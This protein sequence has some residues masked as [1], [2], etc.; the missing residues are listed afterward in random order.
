MK[1]ILSILV[2]L[3][4]LLAV[5]VYM[6]HADADTVY[7]ERCNQDVSSDDWQTW[8][9]TGGDV[10]G[11]HYRLTDDFFGQT[12]TIRIPEN[13]IVCLDLCGKTYAATK[14]R[15]LN[16]MGTFTLM[17]SV[18][19]GTIL[20]SGENG[21]Y[22]GFALVQSSGTFKMYGGTIRYS[23]VP[24][25]SPY[26]GALFYVDGGLLDIK[27]GTIAGGTVAATSSYI[28][29]GGN[30]TVTNSGRL[31]VYGGKITGGTGLKSSSKASQGG[32][33]YANKGSKVIV[34]GGVIENGYVDGGGGNIFIA[35]ASLEV[36]DGTIR[37]GHALVSGGNIMANADTNV[38]NT[39]TISGGE[40]VGGV[41]GGTY[42]TYTD[43]A[44]TRGTKGG[45]NI[46]ERSPSG[47][48]TISG[49][50]IDGDIVLDYVK[51][52]TLSGA[53][54][55]GLGKSGGLT[56]TNLSSFKADVKGLTAGAEIYVQ[57]T[58]VFTTAFD[59][60]LEAEAALVHFK[61]AV[62]T[63]I[64]TTSA[65]ALQGTQGETG[66]C[67]HCGES[68]TWTNLN[69]TATLSGHSYLSAGMLRTSNL[70]VSNTWV[71]DLNGY[72][73]HIE[74]RRFIFN[75]NSAEASL[76]IMD[77]WAGGK[78]Q[79]TGT[80]HSD[81][82]LM[83][84]WPNSTFEL[85]S[86]T[87]CLTSPL[88]DTTSQS[89]IVKCG[90]V[91]FAADKATIKISGGVISN[92]K[93]SATDGYGGN[94]AMI[95]KSGNLE[96][97]AGIINGGTATEL[98]GGNI[99]SNSP[100]NIS[101]GVILN[102]S[103]KNGGN[104]YSN[105]QCNITGGQILNGDATNY[106]GNLYVAAGADISAGLIA[107]GTADTA[108]GNIGL[109][110]GEADISGNTYITG[111]DATGRGGNIAVGSSAILHVSGGTITSGNSS[112]R[113][114]NIDTAT[115]TAIVNIDGG[116][117]L[118]GTATN[119]GNL[120]INNGQ[121]NITG[122]SVMAGAA[123]NGGN[124]YMN[125]F[126]YA[127]I[128]D[129][130]NAST[131][132]AS[133]TYGKATKGN[134][135]NIYLNAADA[136]TNYYLQLG[137][138]TVR[139]GTASGNGKNIY[140]HDNGVFT[141]LSEF[142]GNTTVYFAESRN[143]VKGGL[144]TD[145]CTAT[146]TFSGALL[147]EN[148]EAQPYL[149]AENGKLRVTAAAVV[150][151][152]GSAAWFGSNED[153]V[154]NYSEN[155]AYIIADAGDL[156]LS[157]GSYLVDLSGQIVAIS[158]TGTVTCV[159]SANDDYTK[160]GTATINGPTLANTTQNQFNGNTYITLNDN[161]AY[162]FHRIEMSVD[163]VSIRPANA[164]IYYTCSWNCDDA[165]AAK[166]DTF[167]IALSLRH[168]PDVNFEN[169]PYTLYTK[170]SNED[171]VAGTSANSVLVANVLMQ[172]NQSNN[173]RARM[174]IYATP[175]VHIE[176]QQDPLISAADG[177]AEQS[178]YDIV[179]HVDEQIARDPL[180]YRKLTLPMREFYETWKNDGMQDWD[181]SK[182]PTPPEDDVIDV[183]MIGSSFCYYYV[184]E[185]YGLAEAA[186]VKMRVC[187]VYYSGCRFTWHYTWWKQGKSNYEFYQVTDN[188]GRKKTSG[189]SLEYC[190][191][192]GE[193]DVI[194]IQESTSTI[195]NAGAQNHLDA[196]RSMR[197]ELIGYFKEQFPSAQVYW[198]QPW[199]YQIGYKSGSA[200]VNTFE[201]QQERMMSIREFAIGVT[202]ENGVKRVNT[203]EAWQIYRK[204]YVGTNGLTDTLCARLGVGTNNV[205]DYY[206]DGDI[207]GGQ[208]LNACV[209]F[210][211]IM[212][213]LRPNE[214]YTC[215]GNTYSPVYSGKYT[216]SDE[217]RTALQESAH[218]AVLE[219][220]N[221]TPS[222]EETE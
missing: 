189:V 200:E 120:Y 89:N 122:G 215:I 112:T 213:D 180:N 116:K 8:N 4:V 40:I 87:V 170:A 31:Y 18:G 105:A 30:I 126:V 123:E 142:A 90:G 220:D 76:T 156:V 12:D 38:V 94:I 70:S 77:S 36:I 86:G 68:V 149:S 37:N 85:I 66:F 144:L 74:D 63:A 62:R 209:W 5:G 10:A 19:G 101:G 161:G 49:G 157:G 147:L 50:T 128:K 2:I 130:G 80:G 25:V 151:K 134:G 55:I 159:D 81:G 67:P 201:Q 136:S 53:P 190:L 167:G 28:S 202:Q 171:F 222:T 65:N 183:L 35:D 84:I 117:I 11:G 92:G 91:I 173:D 57:S 186:G 98:P 176:G 42:G 118:L 119:G 106:G 216:L 184:E 3:A 125:H 1:K 152:D 110:G 73:L 47:I 206:H 32:N 185:L 197:N 217:L 75:Y 182:I 174:N 187:N 39:L 138:C 103:A 219:R 27:D 107:G 162:S 71:L 58:R 175:Y 72:T 132:L 160:F 102:G 56:F 22:G 114:G 203:G 61:G 139:D 158:G 131:D 172:N 140:V 177:Q 198:H 133:I 195:Y 96:I 78:L 59:T 44:F 46:Y 83:Y 7:C 145:N 69:T 188:T 179:K 150:M 137:N 108:G 166:V 154:K 148:I 43:G 165:L 192:Q 127:T 129:D 204:N 82:G 153:A 34:Y 14:I 113:A 212:K 221:E 207:G 24:G 111:G 124:I 88:K 115:A 16:V 199:A 41:A 21:K 48:L 29:N 135:G 100:I 168:M 211:T 54:K 194:S 205:G 218:Q 95:G 193:W 163:S 26:S 121:L 52:M 23:K 51:T 15:M 181:L 178:M 169:D 60:A 17:D 99:Y 45:G 146:G 141:V 33:I 143:P 20:S 97:S 214:A 104:I 210:E 109:Y 191:A 6:V 196:T 9:F 13:N 164:G 208:Y 155:A 93:V 79:G 64:S